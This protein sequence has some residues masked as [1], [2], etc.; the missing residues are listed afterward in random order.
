M[1]SE[2]SSI[3]NDLSLTPVSVILKEKAGF[4]T[5]NTYKSLL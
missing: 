4:V 3:E 2:A 1:G 5:Y